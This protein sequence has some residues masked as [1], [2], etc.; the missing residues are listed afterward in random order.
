MKFFCLFELFRKN[1]PSSRH[2]NFKGIDFAPSNKSIMAYKLPF[3]Q[4]GI[5]LRVRVNSANHIAF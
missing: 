5:D 4:F 2:L 3:T 1:Y